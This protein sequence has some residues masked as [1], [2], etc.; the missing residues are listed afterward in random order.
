MFLLSLDAR[1][2]HAEPSGTVA[3][4][5]LGRHPRAHHGPAASQIDRT[6]SKSPSNAQGHQ[7]VLGLLFK[8]HIA[9]HH[10]HR[11][12]ICH[13]IEKPQQNGHAII[14]C[15]VRVENDGDGHRAVSAA[16]TSAK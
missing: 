11:A 3:V 1:V 13:W 8:S 4:N 5:I 16:I 12:Q 2:I 15:C 14:L 6:F 10:R 7:G 9:R